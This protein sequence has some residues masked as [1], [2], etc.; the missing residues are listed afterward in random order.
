MTTKVAT[1][2]ETIRAV[3]QGVWILDAVCPE[4]ASRISL[5]DFSFENPEKCVLGQTFGGFCAGLDKIG[6]A[7][8]SHQAPHLH[9]WASSNGFDCHPCGHNLGLITSLWVEVIKTRQSLEASRSRVG[10][11]FSGMSPR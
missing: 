11:R 1:G 10:Q 9:G 4:W 2:E 3:R 8:Y 6:E 5:A 7:D